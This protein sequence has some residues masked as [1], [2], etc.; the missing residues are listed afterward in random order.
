MRAIC[1]VATTPYFQRGQ[2]RLCRALREAG[3]DAVVFPWE[4]LPNDCPPHDKRPFAFKAYALKAAS[5]CQA[6]SILWCDACILPVRSLEPVW[7]KIERDGYL[8]MNN[9][10]SNY[11]WTADSAYRDLFPSL[12]WGGSAPEVLAEARER[13]RKIPHTVGGFFGISLRHDNGQAFLDEIYRLA[14]DT[15]A[16]CGPTSNIPESPCGPPDVLGHRHDQT[17]MSVIA[18]RLGMKLTDPPEFFIYG[19]AEVATDPR[20]VVVADGSYS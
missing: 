11:T 7:E 3:E 19:K 16:F 5:L 2:Q 4:R 9:G 10:H 12:P 8:L 15:D 14:S 17:A 13:N 1:S 6:D 18:W 20:T